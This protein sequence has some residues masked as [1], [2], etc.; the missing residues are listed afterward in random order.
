METQPNWL[1]RHINLIT[2]AV[3]LYPWLLLILLLWD[4][5]RHHQNGYAALGAAVAVLFLL[6]LTSGMN[7]LISSLVIFCA[8]YSTPPLAGGAAVRFFAMNSISL[9]WLGLLAIWP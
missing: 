7:L 3:A 2:A 4:N 6:A 1:I 8:R 5:Q 9:L